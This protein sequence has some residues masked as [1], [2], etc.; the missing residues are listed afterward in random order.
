[1]KRKKKGKDIGKVIEI[2]NLLIGGLKSNQELRIS[3]LEQICLLVSNFNK[4]Y[5]KKENE[6]FQQLMKEIINSLFI[7]TNKKIQMINN[8]EIENIAQILYEIGCRELNFVITKIVEYLSND[9]LRIDYK[10]AISRALEKLC[11]SF[12]ESMIDYEKQ[13][14]PLIQPILLDTNNKLDNFSQMDNLE[15]QS[16]QSLTVAAIGTFP[17]IMSQDY[18]VNSQIAKSLVKYVLSNEISISFV[19]KDSIERYLSMTSEDEN[20]GQ[21]FLDVIQPVFNILMNF[22]QFFIESENPNVIY[23]KIEKLVDLL[24]LILKTF[25]KWILEEIDIKEND[26]DEERS[27][28][29]INDFDYKNWIDIKY[30][31]QSVCLIWCFF[32]NNTIKKKILNLIKLFN[33]SKFQF[34]EKQLKE[35]F[36][37]KIE[38]KN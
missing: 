6:K 22:S 16:L 17:M 33:N 2:T 8:D 28:Y 38:K 20:E 36:Q 24:E 27:E 25:N 29:I 4:R 15:S 23:D 13:L 12:T 11:D 10:I 19:S 31:F 5:I 21:H 32:D 30:Q 34:V 7:D 1:M 37:K 3:N 14:F 18:E 9:K 35:K 26:D